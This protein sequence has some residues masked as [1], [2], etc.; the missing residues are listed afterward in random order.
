MTPMFAAR[1]R[2]SARVDII[3]SGRPSILSSP[4]CGRNRPQR[5]F[6]KVDLPQPEGPCKN[7]CSPVPNCHFGIRKQAV[8]CVFVWVNSNW[9]ISIIATFVEC[10][11]SGLL[12]DLIYGI[13]CC[14]EVGEYL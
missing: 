9:L 10:N 13:I 11:Y 1:K 4:D 7:S 2:S 6:N 12:C 5:I 3:L 14:R 8:L